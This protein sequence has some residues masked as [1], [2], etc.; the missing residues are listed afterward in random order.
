V[1]GPNGDQLASGCVTP[2]GAQSVTIHASPSGHVAYDTT[3]ADGTNQFSKDRAYVEGHGEGDAD[4]RGVYTAS[5]HVP[6][7]APLGSATLNYIANNR[8]NQLNFTVAATC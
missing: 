1:N 6:A 8:M 5:W 7:N 2:G 4:P 3:Y